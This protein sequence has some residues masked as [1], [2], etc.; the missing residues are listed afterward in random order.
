MFNT[1]KRNITYKILYI[2]LFLFFMQSAFSSLTRA[3]TRKKSSNTCYICHKDLG[4]KAAE[5]IEQWRISVHGESNVTC[6]G[7]H[8][9]DPTSFNRPHEKNTGFRGAPSKA[10]IPEFCA[11]CHSN[12]TW[13]RQFNKR[14]DQLSLYKTS[15]HGRRLLEE[16]DESVATCT[17][18][19]GR[20]EIRRYA[21]LGSLSHHQK[22]AETCASCHSD[23]D[24]MKPYAL[25]TDQLKLYKLS[26]HGQILYNKI[27]D[28][29]PSL[30]P[31]C[32]ECHGIHGAIPAGVTEVA[33]VCG[34][35]HITTQEYFEKSGH[36]EHLEAKGSPRCIDCH[37]YHDILF[38]TKAL[39]VGT[40]K[41]HC[42]YCHNINH[43]HYNLGQEIKTAFTNSEKKV[44]E[45]WERAI[46][47]EINPGLDVLD[48]KDQ[49]E[50]ARLLILE[51]IPIIHTLDLEKVKKYTDEVLAIAN[52]V[53]TSIDARQE[54]FITRK[55]GLFA[56]LVILIL[57]IGFLLFKRW[58]MQL[59]LETDLDP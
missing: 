38:P 26:Y 33:N 2:L 43:K 48:E 55:K 47:I 23:S 20:H 45:V 44:D 51:A 42:G 17:D 40:E 49:L 46:K 11:R 37:A 21:D 34:N 16:G 8:G 15:I 9:G 32:P 28:K 1:Y 18:C 7:C 29:N 30:V 53:D 54:E 36:Y 3:R 58:N 4:K 41:N 24:K 59:E 39:Y 19:H 27:P 6:S 57:M 10:Q 56:T 31:S 35:C 12:P 5:W 22:I 25:R 52:K 13:M 14:T 50:S